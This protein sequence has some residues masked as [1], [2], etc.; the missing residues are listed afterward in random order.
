MG[1]RDPE[2]AYANEKR[3]LSERL[4]QVLSDAADPRVTGDGL[5]FERPPFVNSDGPAAKRQAK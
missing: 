2:P 5:T 4:M 3:E 1:P